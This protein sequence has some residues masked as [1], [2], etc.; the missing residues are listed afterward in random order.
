MAPRSKIKTKKKNEKKTW[1]VLKGCQTGLDDVLLTVGN[2]DDGR[3]V[4]GYS[5]VEAVVGRRIWFF[6]RN[7]NSRST[8]YLE[9][10][11][12][13]VVVVVVICTAIFT[14]YPSFSVNHPSKLQLG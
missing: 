1:A 7:F 3:N 13:H 8:Q 9:Q 6:D 14:S 4:E 12:V 10:K 2:R 11:I 5:R